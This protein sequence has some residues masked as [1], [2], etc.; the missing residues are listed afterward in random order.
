[1]KLN[2]LPINQ[3]STLRN[4]IRWFSASPQVPASLPET[5]CRAPNETFSFSLADILNWI[6]N[7]LL[8]VPQKRLSNNL[9]RD[10]MR[11]TNSRR[12]KVSF[13]LFNKK[14]GEKLCVILAA[15]HVQTFAH[16]SE[17][18]KEDGKGPWKDKHLVSVR[19]TQKRN[20]KIGWEGKQKHCHHNKQFI[21]VGAGNLRYR[22]RRERRGARRILLGHETISLNDFIKL[23]S[24][25]K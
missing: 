22:R 10:G 24:N 2:N 9:S 18:H 6:D 25:N 8:I 20:N 5:F 19:H 17:K 12:E 3:V 23:S 13:I 15:R 16:G 11:T 7:D 21:Y 14:D 1:M 4:F